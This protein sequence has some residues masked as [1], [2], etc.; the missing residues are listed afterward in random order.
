[1]GALNNARGRFIAW[2]DDDQEAGPDWVTTLIETCLKYGAALSFCPT[3]ARIPGASKYNDFYV[4]FFERRGPDT[5]EGQLDTFFGC[6]NSLMDLDNCKLP[7]PV[8]DPIANETGGE[9]DMLFTYIQKHGGKFAWTRSCYTNEDIRPHRATPQYVRVRSFAFGQ[10]PTE[11][12]AEEK[13]IIGVIK[14]MLVGFAQMCIYMPLS[15]GAKILDLKSYIG[16]MAKAYMGAGKIFWFGRF[17][18]KLYGQAAA[19]KKAF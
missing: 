5:A 3:M 16:F 12:A 9:D 6:G 11:M 13:D 2:L 8:F 1:N 15:I 7:T 4:A 10:G 19:Q 18:P 17:K 14:W